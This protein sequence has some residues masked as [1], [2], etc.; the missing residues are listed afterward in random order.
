MDDERES[1]E[2]QSSTYPNQDGSFTL[3]HV[4]RTTYRLQYWLPDGW[5]VR[6]AKFGSQNV[7]EDGLKLADGDAA[8]SLEITISPGVAQVDGVVLRGDDPVPGAMVKLLPDLDNPFRTIWP[9]TTW[10][11]PNGHFVIKNIAPASYRAMAFDV[12]ADP[13]NDDDDPLAVSISLAEKESKT[14]KLQLSKRPE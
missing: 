11:D 1:V 7:L 8:H 4:R 5:Y 3:G 12:E 14:V 6:S 2:G 13:G 9:Q 10:T